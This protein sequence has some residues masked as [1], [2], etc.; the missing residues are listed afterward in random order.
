MDIGTA[1]MERE[2]EWSDKR[3]KKLDRDS[4]AYSDGNGGM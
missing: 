4:N 2:A 3:R 1:G